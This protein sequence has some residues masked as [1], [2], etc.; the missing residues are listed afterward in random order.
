[1]ILSP[2]AN[3]L[4]RDVT[5]HA[6]HFW[7]QYEMWRRNAYISFEGQC[8]YSTLPSFFSV[9]GKAL[10]FCPLKWTACIVTSRDSVLGGGL[11]IEK[12]ESYYCCIFPVWFFLEV[13]F[14]FCC[15]IFLWFNKE[16]LIEL[17]LTFVIFGRHFASW[18]ISV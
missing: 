2:P 1:M 16:L 13:S 17:I 18:F 7:E 4:S 9:T 11:S 14:Y 8:S 15:Q 3:T 10:L 12:G 6:V 5:M